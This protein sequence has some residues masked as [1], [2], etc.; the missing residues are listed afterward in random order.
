MVELGYAVA[1]AR[2]GRGI[3]TAAVRILIDRARAAGATVV[4]AHTLPQPSPS[5]RVLIRCGFTQVG[6]V[7]DPDGDAGRVWRWERRLGRRA[8]DR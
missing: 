3:A 8:S 2:Q 6:E 1:P 7:D 4:R 5:T